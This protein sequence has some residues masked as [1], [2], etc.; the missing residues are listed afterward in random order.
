MKLLNNIYFFKAHELASKL[1]N[2]DISEQLAVKHMVVVLIL[3]GIGFTVPISLEFN[4]S[5]S[6][7]LDNAG[8]VFI[9]IISAFITYRGVWASYQLNCKGDSKEFIFRFT[10]LTLP[11]A[12]LL[13]FYFFIIGLLLYFINKILIPPGII[14]IYSY[15]LI[16]F[17]F[18]II[19]I[20]LFFSKMKKCIGIAS[21]ENLETN[22]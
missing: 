22:V 16:I 6:S 14:G 10:V 9:F 3:S 8:S 13:V 1:R 18:S 11:I 7:F 19:F 17:S 5:Y 12:F 15:Q 4:H 2:G 20:I 21:G